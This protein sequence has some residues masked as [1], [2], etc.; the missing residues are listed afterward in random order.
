MYSA[1]RWGVSGRFVPVPRLSVPKTSEMESMRRMLLAALCAALMNSLPLF[2]QGMTLTGS[3]YASPTT[4]RVSP[5][6]ITTFF[7]S[8]LSMGTAKPQKASSLPLPNSLAGVSVT[9]NQSSPK[10]SLPAPLLAVQQ[11]NGR[12][13]FGDDW[14]IV[15]ET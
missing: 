8:G 5:G 15:T 2:G 13:C 11:L 1:L 12:D 9:I 14:F 3:G 10:Q 6:Q 7:V 4:I